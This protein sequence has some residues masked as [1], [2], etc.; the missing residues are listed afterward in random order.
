MSFG[1]L[2]N[3]VSKPV[4]KEQ[5][6]IAREMRA[7]WKTCPGQE[8]KETINWVNMYASEIPPF[9]PCVIGPKYIIHI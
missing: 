6:N 5:I 4:D 2:M 7:G 3:L 8:P 1:G 9:L